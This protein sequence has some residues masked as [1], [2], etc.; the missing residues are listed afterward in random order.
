MSNIFVQATEKTGNGVVLHEID[1]DHPGGEIYIAGCLRNVL[2]DDRRAILDKDGQP[3]TEANIVEVAKTP[4]VLLR[5]SRG[6][7][8]EAQAQKK[9]VGTRKG[10]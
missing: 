2:G 7:L 8:V 9:K 4:K 10:A 5:L 3:K 6:E 1:P